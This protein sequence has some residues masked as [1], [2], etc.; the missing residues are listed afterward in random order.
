MKE[1]RAICINNW[2][3]AREVFSGRILIF[4]PSDSTEAGHILPASEIYLTKDE[5][6]K[7]AEFAEAETE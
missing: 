5:I 7:L 2:I 4:S 3:T 1:Q 6:K